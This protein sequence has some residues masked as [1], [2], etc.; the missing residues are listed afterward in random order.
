MKSMEKQ[1]LC[2]NCEGRIPIEMEI[3]PY[4]AYEL[5]N[6][7]TKPQSPLFQK[8]SLEE[9]L[10]SLYKPPYQGR[11]TAQETMEKPKSLTS[12]GVEASLYG[13]SP[14]GEE[15]EAQATP[16]K[17]SLWPTL[18][19]LV[20]TNLLLLGILQLLFGENGVV[21]LQWETGNWFF[22]CL[23]SI[24]LFYFGWKKLQELD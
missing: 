13:S 16:K 2:P 19:L 4:C 23:A 10:A 1:K 3:C 15:E 17:S 12:K 5:T 9:S 20:G 21:H 7:V 11:T 22:Y 8:Q 6:S 14:A 18:L 24:P